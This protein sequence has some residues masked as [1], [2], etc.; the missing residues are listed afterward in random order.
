MGTSRRRLEY[1]LVDSDTK[2]ATWR[3]ME[4]VSGS[5]LTVT[6]RGD[7]QSLTLIWNDTAFK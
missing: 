5:A 7:V 1:Y 3:R 4:R 2:A 6:N